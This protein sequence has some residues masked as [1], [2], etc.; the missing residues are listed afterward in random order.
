MSHSVYLEFIY[1]LFQTSQTS[2][3]NSKKKKK[4]KGI[5]LWE[6][7]THRNPWQEF[8][9]PNFETISQAVLRGERPYFDARLIYADYRNLLLSCWHGDPERRPSFNEILSSDFFLNLESDI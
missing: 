7:A 9:P 3:C 6:L 4:K 8:P 1:S 5:V 2:H